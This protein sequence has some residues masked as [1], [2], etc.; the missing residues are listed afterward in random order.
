MSTI[1]PTHAALLVMDFQVGIVGRVGDQAGPL[2]ERVAGVVAAARKAMCPCCTWWS[3][4][5]PATPS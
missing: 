4:S 1:E 5:G 3:P 2:L